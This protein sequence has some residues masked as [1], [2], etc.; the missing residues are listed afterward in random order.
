MY[1]KT[2]TVP[3]FNRTILECKWNNDQE[4]L[5]LLETLIELY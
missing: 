3:T 1:L 4:N 5:Q 2:V